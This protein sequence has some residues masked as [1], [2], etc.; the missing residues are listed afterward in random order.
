[1]VFLSLRRFGDIVSRNGY[2]AQ[3]V[4]L[5]PSM[6]EVRPSINGG[7]GGSRDDTCHT[8]V[9]DG[10]DNHTIVSKGGP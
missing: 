4:L 9:M 2:G 8:Q 10:L 7:R 3:F 5:R 1:M 6:F